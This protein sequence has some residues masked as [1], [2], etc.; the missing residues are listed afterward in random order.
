MMLAKLWY[1]ATVYQPRKNFSK[2]LEGEIFSIMWRRGEK[3]RRNT[4]F[5]TTANGGIG[6]INHTIKIQALW[7]KHI[8]IA[9]K[10]ENKMQ[11]LTKY[12]CA[13]VKKI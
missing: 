6:L 3:I 8:H 9:F 5:Q 4:L 2:W 11:D 13:S 7:L 1:V 12:W 10:A